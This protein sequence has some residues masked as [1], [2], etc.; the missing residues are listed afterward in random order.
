MYYTG[1]LKAVYDSF[2][3]SLSDFQNAISKKPN[4]TPLLLLD[5]PINFLRYTPTKRHPTL[6]I[7][8]QNDLF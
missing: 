2:H 1:G 3:F 7:L 6:L 4:P 5:F 8:Q